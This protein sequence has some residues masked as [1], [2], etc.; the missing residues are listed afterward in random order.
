MKK[1]LFI[2]L[3]PLSVFGQ[4]DTFNIFL[5]HDFENDTIGPYT[6]TQ[7]LADFDPDICTPTPCHR[8]EN[9][10][11]KLD[12]EKNSN[13][14]EVFY[15]KDKGNTGG[16]Y[17]YSR[18]SSLTEVYM[19]FSMRLNDNFD[20]ALSG[21]LH[22][23][24]AEEGL[25]PDV[26]VQPDD[27]FIAYWSWSNGY[28]YVPY[29]YHQDQPGESAESFL[30]GAPF[31]DLNDTSWH[32]LTYRLVLN[33]IASE[34]NG[35]NDGILEAFY[36]GV[37]VWGKYDFN[38]RN[39]SSITID[40]FSFSTFYGGGD[41]FM[42]RPV[43]DQRIRFDDIV[44]WNYADAFDGEV[45]GNVAGDSGRVIPIPFAS[46]IEGEG[47]TGGGSAICAEYWQNRDY[48]FS[49]YY[50]EYD[51]YGQ[52]W[53]KDCPAITT[54]D[55]AE[56]YLMKIGSPGNLYVSVYETDGDTLP[57]GDPI[58]TGIING[59]DL[60]TTYTLAGVSLTPFNPVE[61]SHYVIAIV[62]SN[63][64]VDNYI[65]IGA[66]SP[67]GYTDGRATIQ[68]GSWTTN[69]DKDILFRMIGQQY[70]TVCTNYEYYVPQGTLLE[71]IKS[72]NSEA[73][74]FTVGH[75]GLNQNIDIDSIGVRLFKTGDPENTSF[76]I[77]ETVGAGI[78]EYLVSDTFNADYITTDSVGEIVWLKPP[79][80][81]YLNGHNYFVSISGGGV[82]N[83]NELTWIGDE[84]GTYTGGW[85]VYYLNN[86]WHFD[87]S[88]D[89]SFEIC[90]HEAIETTPP[91]N[92]AMF[93]G[94][95]FY[96]K[97]N[98]QNF[99]FKQ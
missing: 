19:T 6:Y 91:T 24:E 39:Y 28:G 74:S 29:I 75:I 16:S 99:K 41:D 37:Q 95:H 9:D 89:L 82:D 63:Y 25:D 67:G 87:T 61:G 10:S 64:T 44:M 84:N 79:Y 53:K 36:N 96:L 71:D 77:Y 15:S 12:S 17:W 49:S 5:S 70:E 40:Y 35:N 48:Y 92:N 38:F 8:I 13:V 11:I 90:A 93:G 58:S 78:Y 45:K 21:K 14:L 55:S 7:W 76:S 56:F 94:Q 69:Y 18:I 66:S 22:A 51:A 65:Q 33:T 30:I 60:N 54:I 86:D 73:Q 46:A 83:V 50:D 81:K 85:N 47:S 31:N 57:V 52:S 72:G 1:L 62:D 23:I 43:T 59:N 42:W 98:G 80:Y 20:Q 26:G 97:V 3:F 27:P 32:Q 2:L 4:S 88:I 68:L 34:G